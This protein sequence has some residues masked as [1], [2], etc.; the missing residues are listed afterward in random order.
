MGFAQRRRSRSPE[1]PKVPS[2]WKMQPQWLHVQHPF[3]PCLWADVSSHPAAPA[4]GSCSFITLF[5]SGAAAKDEPEWRPWLGLSARPSIW[6]CSPWCSFKST[7]RQLPSTCEEGRLCLSLQGCSNEASHP[8]Q[9]PPGCFLEP[10][11]AASSGLR[12]AA[13]PRPR[14]NLTGAFYSP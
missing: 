7:A 14:V 11:R 9:R 6:S 4:V 2:C 8:R 10:P 1:Q 13:A 5:L 12:E 3:P